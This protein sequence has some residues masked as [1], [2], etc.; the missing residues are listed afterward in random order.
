MKI[1]L[2]FVCCSA[3]VLMSLKMYLA[4]LLEL[5]NRRGS[6]WKSSVE[7]AEESNT[8]K[9]NND[10]TVSQNC[11]SLD[12]DGGMDNLLSRYKQVFIEMPAKAAGTTFK[13]FTKI[14]M[15]STNTSSFTQF[16]NILNTP[17]RIKEALASQLKMPSLVASHVAHPR[18]MHNT[19][20]HATE[21]TLIVYIYR[22][23]TSRLTSAI[24]TGYFCE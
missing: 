18:H 11:L 23:E 16:N 24:N 10:K 7:E 9:Q 13:H 15:D 5:D 6:E 20:V 17:E 19:F 12:F 14:C 2:F 22:E 4:S 21:E 1:T 3:L 8:P